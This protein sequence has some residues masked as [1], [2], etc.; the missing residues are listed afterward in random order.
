MRLYHLFDLVQSAPLVVLNEYTP[1]MSVRACV[2]A[3]YISNKC[4]A[5]E[6]SSVT[7]ENTSYTVDD[8]DNYD[9]YDDDDDD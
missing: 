3:A 7:E 1:Q 2:C 6:V 8:D 9:V 5:M 4:S